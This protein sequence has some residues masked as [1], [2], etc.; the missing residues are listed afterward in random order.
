MA[1]EYR[2][3]EC[4]EVLTAA[5]V[6]RELDAGGVVT[7]TAEC[8]KCRRRCTR[9]LAV[10]PGHGWGKA[11][12]FAQCNALRMFGPTH[13][14]KAKPGTDAA[15]WEN[16]KA[17]AVTATLPFRD[18]FDPPDKQL[19]RPVLRG[20]GGK[21][22][23]RCRALEG[24]LNT[25]HVVGVEIDDKGADGWLELHVCLA[26]PQSPADEQAAVHVAFEPRHGIGSKINAPFHDEPDEPSDEPERVRCPVCRG[27]A[28]FPGHGGVA[29]ACDHCGGLGTVIP[30][31]RELFGG[32]E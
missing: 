6:F 16:A 19:I 21:R 24:L 13:A 27:Q 26:L 17:E 14:R 30:V 12:Q 29:K 11:A 2:C 23:E 3:S 7:A 20:P 5:C 10:E 9:S 4:D 18:I 22:D 1:T 25:Y 8:P 32:E 28:H 31:Q 15:F